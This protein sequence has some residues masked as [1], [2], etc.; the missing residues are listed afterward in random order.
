[1]MSQPSKYNIEYVP[2][3][4]STTKQDYVPYIP[5]KITKRKYC[6]LERIPGAQKYSENYIP[7]CPSKKS[8]GIYGSSITSSDL[9]DEK[10]ILEPIGQFYNSAAEE[11]VPQGLMPNQEMV[12]YKPSKIV[13]SKP[14]NQ[15][16]CDCNSIIKDN[17]I[18]RFTCM[19]KKEIGINDRKSDLYKTK[20]RLTE[21]ILCIITKLPTEIETDSIVAL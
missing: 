9:D 11:Y 5:S 3:S 1:M 4:I 13:R 21:E 16:S 2:K 18:N 17:I 6:E 12:P 7:F 10:Y 19:Y 15:K 20:M 14:R 8:K